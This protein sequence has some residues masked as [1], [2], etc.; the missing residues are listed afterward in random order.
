MQRQNQIES[1]RERWD[2]KYT[3][4]EGPA[5][6]RPEQFLIKNRHLLTGGRALD[7]ACGL[8]GNA[9]YLAS[10]GYQV[11]ALDVSSVALSGARAEAIRRGTSVNWI[12]VDVARWSFPVRYYDLITVFF[13]LNRELMPRLALSLRAQGLLFQANHNQRFLETRPDFNPDYLLESDELQKWALDAGLRVL[14]YA[15]NAPGQAHSSQL[16]ARQS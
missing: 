11:D 2:R 15:D 3:A 9:M 12:Q 16:I 7:V 5:H 10:R 6:F 1:D 14:H 4:R 8:G 13:Y